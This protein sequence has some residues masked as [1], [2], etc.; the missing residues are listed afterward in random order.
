MIE[1]LCVVAFFLVAFAVALVLKDLPT[2]AELEEAEGVTPGRM[3][4]RPARSPADHVEP[5][6]LKR[7][8]GKNSGV[9]NSVA[10]EPFLS[11][12]EERLPFRSWTP[13]ELAG[14][15]GPDWHTPGFQTAPAVRCMLIEP[16]LLDGVAG[17][18][19]TD[20]FVVPGQPDMC[21]TVVVLFRPVG[22]SAREE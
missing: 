20:Q 7:A 13:E 4:D 6:D 21:V 14:G 2:S 22:R 16:D 10:T 15:D 8:S 5:P 19:A 3:D 1:L 12:E 9:R 17:G 11:P 18:E